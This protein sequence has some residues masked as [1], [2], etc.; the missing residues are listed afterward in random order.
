MKPWLPIQAL[1][2][3][4]GVVLLLV[5]WQGSA[6][7]L[8]PLVLSS[9]SQTGFTLLEVLQHPEPLLHLGHTLERASLALSCAAA[10]GIGLGFLAGFYAPIAALL[11]PL[12]WLLMSIPPVVMVIL[13][14][15]W[16]GLGET[17]VIGVAI[18]LLTPAIYVHTANAIRMLDPHWHELAHVYRLPWHLRFSQLYLPAIAAPLC[19]AL[20]IAL[21][22]SIRIV[23]LAEVLGSGDGMGYLLSSARSSFATQQLFAWVALLLL[24][25]AF[26]EWLILHPLQAHLTRWKK[27]DRHAVTN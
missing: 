10:L 18:A 4:G 14:M 2:L 23:V 25:T 27:E 8:G 20:L 16:L 9:P 21:C 12:R 22:S 24:V 1:W 17:M 6:T 26:L 19:A 11:A 7:L 3:S 5:A 15:F 13:A